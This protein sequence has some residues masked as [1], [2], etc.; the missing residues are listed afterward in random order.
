MTLTEQQVAQH[1]KDLDIL[2][3]T[4]LPQFL[5]AD[6][7][8]QTRGRLEALIAENRTKEYPG[9]S[10]YRPDDEQLFNL[11]N[12]DKIFIDLL[13][14]PGIE[15]I[16]MKRLNDPYYPRLPEDHPNYILGELI[17]RSSGQKLRMHIDSWMPAPGPL[18][19]M[20]QVVFV[21]HDRDEQDGCSLVVP[22][23]H[24]SG[25]YTDREFPNAIAAPVKAG[26]V[27]LWDSRLWHGA[28]PRERED[29]K[30]VVIATVQRW[31]VKQRFDIPRALPADIY[32][33]LSDRQRMLLGYGS[34]PPLTEE[35]QTDTRG[36]IEAIAH[37]RAAMA[38]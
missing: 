21:M 33:S 27:V 5:S 10:D 36:G 38:S 28:L 30:W 17:A 18:A 29:K 16:L 20:M 37:N 23:S 12:K 11:Q 9:Y 13:G 22:G 7:L 15:Q 34:M 4:V 26:D 35:M 31:W 1:C 25:E 14:Q 32:D 2:G 3:Y 8:A 24:R 19:W 6:L